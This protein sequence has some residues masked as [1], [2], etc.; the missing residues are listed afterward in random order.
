M[1]Q[2]TTGIRN[3]GRKTNSA[4]STKITCK[5]CGAGSLEKKDSYRLSGP[6][7]A[8]GYILLL[9]AFIGMAIGFF[10]LFT[11]SG[12]AMN[13][14]LGLP[15]FEDYGTYIGALGS[16]YI[17]VSSFTG[18]LLGFLLIMKKKTLNCSFCEATTPAS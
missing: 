13:L 15:L 6:V 16:G 12:W 17:I 3:L 2:T 4:P 9:P 14:F 8:I 7:V 11:A 18:G 5:I 1:T 10:G